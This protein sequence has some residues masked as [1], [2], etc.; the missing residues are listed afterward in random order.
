MVLTAL[1]GGC[2]KASEGEARPGAAQTEG[3]RYDDYSDELINMTT[4][5]MDSEASVSP[6]QTDPPGWSTYHWEETRLS[7]SA[8]LWAN[9]NNRDEFFLTLNNFKGDAD[10]PFDVTYLVGREVSTVKEAPQATYWCVTA[11]PYKG[12]ALSVVVT[13]NSEMNVFFKSAGFLA[14]RP[15]D[16]SC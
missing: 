5:L 8:D 9:P 7:M 4:G 2:R 13:N 1:L 3:G 10:H 12:S 14:L 6:G 15:G 11:G 16:Y